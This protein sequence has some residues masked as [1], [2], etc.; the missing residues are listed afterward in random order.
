[1]RSQPKN[2]MKQFISLIVKFVDPP[3][4]T[5]RHP[6]MSLHLEKALSVIQRGAEECLEVLRDQKKKLETGESSDM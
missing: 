1:M 4:L 6:V 3:V 5:G 2:T